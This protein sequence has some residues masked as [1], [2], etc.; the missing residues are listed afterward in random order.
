MIATGRNDRVIDSLIDNNNDEDD[1]EDIP[2]NSNLEIVPQFISKTPP[3][4]P[5]ALLPVIRLTSTTKMPVTPAL[6]WLLKLFTTLI[7][8]CSPSKSCNSRRQ[9]LVLSF[10]YLFLIHSF[11]FI[12]F[13]ICKRGFSL[14][15]WFL[16]R[17]DEIFQLFQEIF[18]KQTRNVTKNRNKLCTYN[19]LSK[20]CF[21]K[22]WVN[23]GDFTI[24]IVNTNRLT[25]FRMKV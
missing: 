8:S 3:P 20:L 9:I 21:F 22:I 19:L 18:D 4:P 15:H 16:P 5:P 23:T 2:L 24:L 14:R 7:F 11:R 25:K 6:F 1:N 13:Y 10:I 12:V 17:T